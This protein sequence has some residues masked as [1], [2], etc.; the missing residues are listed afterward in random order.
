MGLASRST[1]AARVSA[2]IFRDAAS[3]LLKMRSVL[4]VRNKPGDDE[5]MGLD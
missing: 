1:R 4:T 5:G 2:A 3:R